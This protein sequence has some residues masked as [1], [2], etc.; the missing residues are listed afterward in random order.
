MDKK[1]LQELVKKQEQRIENLEQN[2]QKIQKDLEMF[3]MLSKF[4]TKSS[5][6]SKVKKLQ[7]ENK[8]L[9]E[10]SKELETIN[11]SLKD[12][13][14][15][16]KVELNNTISKNEKLENKNLVLDKE[17]KNNP[18]NEIN[19]LYNQ[20]DENTKDGIKN[21]LKNKDELTLFA[22]STLKR[23]PLW[24]Y[25]KHLNIEHK[26]NEFEI[27]HNIFQKVF[28]T[29]SEIKDIKY[30]IVKVGD[31][32]DSEFHTRDNRSQEFD[33][34]IQEVVLQ[35]L[36]EDDRIVKKAIVRV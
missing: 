21:I 36:V 30:Q 28:T 32:F 2:M 3:N 31:E 24:E 10:H 18:L 17:L 9:K 1:E 22:S 34:A 5:D 13:Q 12:E 19:E 6:D 20:L 25:L 35:G 4:F 29:Y 14:K 15:R 27:L 33:G 11:N 16:L 8:H 23:E 26:D 7:E